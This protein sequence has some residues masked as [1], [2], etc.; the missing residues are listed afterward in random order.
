MIY[1]HPFC[2]PL[3]F[4]LKAL[5]NAKFVD[6][7]QDLVNNVVSNLK[8]IFNAIKR[9]ED[10]VDSQAT[11][12]SY[13]KLGISSRTDFPPVSI[14]IPIFIVL[15]KLHMLADFGLSFANTLE[16]TSAPNSQ[17]PSHVLLPSSLYKNRTSE[18]RKASL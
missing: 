11:P 17:S 9:A 12:V 8:S 18:K 3:A 7:D 1:I 6:G 15:Q 13:Y 16:K 14:L 2:S 5:V 4:T 10:A